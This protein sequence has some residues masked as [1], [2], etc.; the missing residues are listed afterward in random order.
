M[1]SLYLP[2]FSSLRQIQ[3]ESIAQKRCVNRVKL[4]EVLWRLHRSWILSRC[5]TTIRCRKILQTR[6]Q[7]EPQGRIYCD[8]GVC[9]KIGSCSVVVARTGWG[10]CRL[11]CWG[12]QPSV[13][14]PCKKKFYKIFMI[15]FKILKL[16]CYFLVRWVDPNFCTN[17][18]EDPAHFSKRV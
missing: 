11:L 9:L 7:F 13:L 17:C 10:S 2:P 8:W 15:K 5:V 3:A 6:W 4:F 18:F 16:A 12:R 14:L 1:T